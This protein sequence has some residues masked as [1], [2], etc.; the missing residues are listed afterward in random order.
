MPVLPRPAARCSARRSVFTV[1]QRIAKIVVC[2][3]ESRRAM[4]VRRILPAASVALVA[5]VFSPRFF[6]QQPLPATQLAGQKTVR[7]KRQATRPMVTG[8][9]GAQTGT[10]NFVGNFTT[11]STP[12]DAL[13]VFR[14]P[15]CSLSLA[16][17]TY[18]IDPFMYTQSELSANYERVLHSEAQLT[19]TPDVFANGCAMQPTLGFGSQLGIFVGTTTTGVNVFA[20]IGLTY[21]SL[22]EGVYI[23][24]GE[25]TFT[26]SSF[27]DSSAGNLTAADLNKDGNG[28]LV[29]TNMSLATSAY[30]TVMLGN[31]DGT[32]QNGVSYPIAGDYSVAAVIDDVN[33]DG[34]PDIVAVSGDQQ[35]SVLLGN[36]NGTFQAAQS[37][38][39]P[40]LPGYTTAASTPIQN[41]ITADLRGNGKKDIIC[42]N[43]LVLLGNG[44]GTFTAASTPA[45]PYVTDPLYQGGPM[46]ASGDLNNDGKIDLVLNDGLGI[47]TWI[48]KGDGTFTEGPS[49]STIPTDGYIAIDDLDG[50]GNADVFVG[51]GDGGAYGG[52][53][54][55]LQLAYALMG[56]GNGTFQGAPQLDLGAYTGTNLGDVTGSG[57]LDLI[58]NNPFGNPNT[59]A[60]AFT[61]QL[62]TGKGTFTPTSTITAPA[63]FV[64]NGYTITGANTAGAGTYAVGDINGDGK[65]DLVFAD[66]G[67][68][69][70]DPG[71]QG[72][73]YPYP[74]YF[75]SISNGDG[76][77]QTPVPYAFPQIAPAGDF[78]N[79]L[80][81]SGMQITNFSKGGNAG[82]IFTF[83]EF[84]G[85]G[86]GGPAVSPYSQG[87][88]VLPGNGNGTFA[89]PVITTT[90]TGTTTLNSLPVI[91]AISDVNGDGNPDLI[92]IN[93]SYVSG[94]GA[95]S[96][97]EVFLGNGD[98]TFK[99]PITLTTPANPTAVVIADFNNDG[100]PDIAVICGAINANND[101]IAVL[102]GNGDGTFTSA[103][104]LTISS[105]I[106][107]SAALAAA[108]FNG[109]GNIDLALIN[110]YGYSGIFY[111]NGNG[112]FTSVNTGSYVVPQDLLNIAV[113]G[114]AVAVDLNGDGKPDILVGNTILLNQGASTTSTLTTPTVTVSPLPASITTAQSTMV[115][116]TVSGSGATPTGS[117]TL[118]SGAYTSAATALT[119]GAVITV[120]GSALAV[121]TDTLTATYTPDSSSASTYNS[122]TGMN[123][124]TV[125]A[126]PAPSF[127]LSNSGN[128]SFE[129]GATT[130]NTAAIMVSP[131]NGF[132]GTVS[133]TCAVTTTPANPTSPATCGVT[134]S[135]NVSGASPQNATLT[136]TT[137]TTTT[138]GAYAVT[139]TGTSGAISM[140]TIVTANVSAYV[141]PSFTLT[142]SG[143]V[144]ISSPGATTGNTATITVTP[145]G[146]FTGSVALTAVLASSPSGATDPPTFSFGATS[147]VSITGASNG[148]GT[149]TVSTT[150][151]TTA[152]LAHPKL[153]R[154]PWY[155]TGAAALAC[156][157][158]FGIP[159]RRRRWR[160][161]V[162]MF[163]LLAFLALGLVSCGGK[164]S[165]SGSGSGNSGNPGT[166][167]GN[168]TVT[169]TGTSGSITQ[170]TTVSLTVN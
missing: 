158:F 11:I 120:P 105:D 100:K 103:G 6:A 59:T 128:I 56:N 85:Q 129:A 81:V 136:I 102:L 148:T 55:S 43:G 160:S 133:L 63:S 27:Q 92:V 141:A 22:V 67:L 91:A 108:D 146:G 125:T 115:T 1:S 5:L 75:T 47:S 97:V 164:S 25:T 99:T 32:F 15:N 110:Y 2:I 119:S 155:A 69:T 152:A 161:L 117:V 93:N 66:S 106:N 165:S 138:A 72:I 123:T 3:R 31:A 126:A 74:V 53:P 169:V 82:L 94:V 35:I 4:L 16:T 118:T 10:A 29:I 150:A 61:V 24:S 68:D 101:E 37:F 58:T 38:A 130:G 40:V 142:N 98:G 166:T 64:V 151:A 26:L 21:P 134:P 116:V 95:E 42:S 73:I 76:T 168:Y 36:G 78:D 121:A 124:V 167:T 44:N 41:L 154:A 51:I 96:Q 18:T 140:P 14:E 147:P 87:F 143:A 170:S 33:G 52:D 28:D 30:V 9:N 46:L 162:G 153:R 7:P 70:V 60:P 45:F 122:A 137:T 114:P 80:T 65:A 50:D 12:A 39:A 107:G 132:T 127:T 48:G 90:A 163:V 149:L 62:G 34:I 71:G 86:I 131:S 159:A 57:T 144:T 109:D 13:S 8:T 112:T 79:S 49:Y 135:V 77:F 84:A 54:S 89:S 113:S 83:N 145:G 88:V 157:L 139:V 20:G 23:L 19:T 17:G 104:T 156:L 111:G